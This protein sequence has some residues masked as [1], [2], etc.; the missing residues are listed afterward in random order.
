MP[1]DFV[2]IGAGV[3]GSTAAF[4]LS[5]HP[6]VSSTSITFIKA[7]TSGAAQG[8]SGKAGGLVAKWAY[9]KALAEVSFKEHM[10]L[11]ERFDGERKWGWRYVSAGEWV[12]R[13]RDPALPSPS[14]NDLKDMKKTGLPEDLRWISE[15][16]TD[17]Y[18]PIASPGDTAQVH[19]YL[20]TT[21]ILDVA[22]EKGVRFVQGAVT[23]LDIVSGHV[24]G[25]RYIPHGSMEDVYLPSDCVIL[26]AGA[27]SQALLPS[28]NIS[29]LCGHSIVIRTPRALPA[30][31]IS[32]YALFTSIS[33]PPR[34][35]ASPRVV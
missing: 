32:P 15:T 5:N 11:A 20:F 21:N 14:H 33:L 12:G 28:L 34:G 27:W 17:K 19:P 24:R 4:Y 23:S 2:I 1:T 3:I 8:A 10:R 22:V 16:M 26:A 9:P 18:V 31:A 30:D 6:N 7:S 13:G 35:G 29:G 25:V